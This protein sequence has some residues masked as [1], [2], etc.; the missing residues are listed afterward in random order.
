[1]LHLRHKSWV[2]CNLPRGL[3]YGLFSLLIMKAFMC[4]K[5]CK[6]WAAETTVLLSIVNKVFS[7]RLL[8]FRHVLENDDNGPASSNLTLCENW[9]IFYRI[10][11]KLLYT[12]L[13][14]RILASIG[15]SDDEYV[16]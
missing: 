9:L 5:K 4:L 16:D 3:L 1:M 15:R 12:S 6:E 14:S 7:F 2:K 13:P 8:L 11:S 10:L